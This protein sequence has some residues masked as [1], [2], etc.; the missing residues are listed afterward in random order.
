MRL[1]AQSPSS[2]ANK[3]LIKIIC[4]L[5]WGAFFQ[6][7]TSIYVRLCPGDMCGGHSDNWQ[8]NGTN[9]SRLVQS[10][11]ITTIGM[12]KVE[13]VI[14]KYICAGQRNRENRH[15]Y[16]STLKHASKW[17]TI[18]LIH[19]KSESSWYERIA[20]GMWRK[21]LAKETNTVIVSLSFSF[22][23]SH[24]LMLHIHISHGLC[25]KFI[26]ELKYKIHLVI[27]STLIYKNEKKENI[28]VESGEQAMLKTGRYSKQ[29]TVPYTTI[30][31]YYT[32]T[33]WCMKQKFTSDSSLSSGYEVT[34]FVRKICSIFLWRNWLYF[35]TL[36]KRTFSLDVDS[37]YC[38]VWVVWCVRS[39]LV[40]MKK[41][42][43]TSSPSSSCSFI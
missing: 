7:I 40:K 35:T 13:N 3:R 36:F 37:K 39:P 29:Y 24:S 32:Q 30:P 38:S 20:L 4:L 14:F 41:W 10:W 17:P 21:R 5:L 42:T 6:L 22:V 27:M 26:W 2:S 34:R 28:V 16:L 19:K 15:C 12:V 43:E 8:L 25:V 11:I 31:V 1:M 18:S 9:K 33:V 23:C